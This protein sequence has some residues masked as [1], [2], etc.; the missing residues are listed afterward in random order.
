MPIYEYRCKKNGHQFELI[1]KLSDPP[2]KK[3]PRCGSK[4]E[5][6]ISAGAFV[7]K[8]SGFYVNDYVRKGKDEKS[9]SGKSEPAK[10]EAKAE[11]K[12]ESKAD[13]AKP[14]KS[15]AKASS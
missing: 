3:C 6:L 10:T 13:N 1:Q 4:V 12:N 2:P 11:T 9:E 15:K 8:G 5:K 7:L 14:E